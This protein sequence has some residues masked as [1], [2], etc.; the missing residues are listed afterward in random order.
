MGK[1]AAEL[2]HV[3]YLWRDED[4]DRLSGVDRLVYRSN[5][6]GDDLTLTNT[7][8]GNTSS[9]LTEQRPAHRRARRGALGEGLG[10]RPA[11]GDAGRLCVALSRQGP[12][13]E[14]ALREQPR[15]R[16]EDADRG[17]DVPDV[18]PL[19]LQPEPARLLDRHAA[20]HVRPVPARRSPAPERGHRRRRLGE[21][22][23]AVRARSTAT[24]S[25]TSPGS[26][27]ASTSG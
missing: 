1:N 2:Q 25:S 11:D 20:A 13:D 7:G 3:K 14:A 19:R 24:T 4:A 6:L 12:G 23:A 10:R 18:Q 17:R 22:G 5:R 8:G 27:P 9:K 21:P 16:A 26:G 15:A